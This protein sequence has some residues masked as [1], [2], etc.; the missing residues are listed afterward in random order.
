MIVQ[1]LSDLHLEHH[2]D[3][4]ESFL[5]S[6]D[7]TGVDVLI[8]AGDVLQAMFPERVRHIFRAFLERYPH[9]L[10]VPGNHEYYGSSPVEANAVLEGIDLPNF[11]LLNPGTVT[12]GGQRSVGATLWFP[13]TEDEVAYRG[14]VND[15][16]AIAGAVPWIHE[17]HAAHRR[18]LDATIAPGDVVITHHLPALPSID[19][20]YAGSPSNRFFW[21]A[22]DELV[23]QRGAR[24]WVHG[25]THVHVDYV[26]G[27]T[28][29]VA[30]PLG[31][32][33]ERGCRFVERMLR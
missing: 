3:G 15:F 24:L 19:P 16:S 5:R 29:V 22:T 28:R 27:E 1:L 33:Y 31:Y 7:S 26:L 6:L 21:A 13:R 2:R 18:Y 12:L 23:E 32:P 17:T 10:Y 9:V 30:N 25:H 11:H 4:G 8:L 20:R 14:Y